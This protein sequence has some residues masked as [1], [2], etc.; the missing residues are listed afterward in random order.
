MRARVHP[1]PKR[2]PDHAAV[3]RAACCRTARRIHAHA[4][5]RLGLAT[6]ENSTYSRDNGTVDNRKTIYRYATNDL[7]LVTITNALEPLSPRATGSTPPPCSSP[8][9]RVQ[10]KDDLVLQ[11]ET[12]QSQGCSIHGLNTTQTT[13]VGIN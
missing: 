3:R 8:I 12:G 6:E 1:T 5:E 10:R 11:L 7:D 2:L 4:A 9:Q 13:T